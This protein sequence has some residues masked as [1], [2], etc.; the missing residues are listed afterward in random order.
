MASL[1]LKVLIIKDLPSQVLD[2]FKMSLLLRNL[3][4]CLMPHKK[5]SLVC[6]VIYMDFCAIYKIRSTKHVYICKKQGLLPP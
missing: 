3:V 6:Q 1:E 2:F 4:F 5:N